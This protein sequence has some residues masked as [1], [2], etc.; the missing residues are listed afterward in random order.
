MKMHGIGASNGIAV[1]KV[2]ILKEETTKISNNKVEEKNLN[3]EINK[4]DIAIVQVKNDLE[5]LVVTTREKLGDEHAAIFEAHLSILADPELYQQI[6]SL[7]NDEKWNAAKAV[8]LACDS[9]Y[10]IFS[11]LDD[12]YL[13]ERAADILDIKTKLLNQILGIKDNFLSEIKEEVIIVANDLTPSQTSQLNPKFVKGF[14]CNIGG[15]TSHSAIMARSLGIPAIVGLKNITTQVQNN[16][17]VALNG[18]SGLV[19]LNLSTEEVNKWKHQEKSWVNLKAELTSFKGKKT[20]T[21]DNYEF[22]LEA[23]VGSSKDLDSAIEN[24]AQGIGLFRTEFLYME[25]TDFPTE[26]EQFNE[27]KIALEKMHPY[28]VVIRTLD[29]GGDKKLS[30]WDLP[31][32]LNPFL[33]YRAIRLCLDQKDIFRTQ[34]RA[35]L[36]ASVYGQLGIMF[37]MIATVEEFKEAKAFVL[38]CKEELIKEG[39]KVSDNVQIGMMIE[40]PSSAVNAHIFSKYADFFSIGTNDLIQYSLAADRMSEKVS[41]LYQPYHPAVLRLIKMTIDGAKVHEK[42]IPV[43]MCGEMAGDSIAAP[44]LVGMGLDEFSMSASDI[45]STRKLINSLS[46]KDMELLVEQALACETHEE[47]EKLVTDKLNQILN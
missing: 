30:Y 32:E 20:I 34:I 15:R 16:E 3:S 36:R 18:S 40:I 12:E 26:E 39:Q 21:K 27:Y 14:L 6:K 1:S 35:L 46:K 28:K 13:R 4:V 11:S 42:K 47:V 31:H 33:G 7:I 2:L 19:E 45:L 38:Q 5:K 43:G 29:I 24:D 9:F 22:K 44:L 10:Q 25:N 8:E 23:N 37:P 17:Y 41:Y